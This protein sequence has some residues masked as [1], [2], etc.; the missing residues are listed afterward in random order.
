MCIDQV[1]GPAQDTS[2]D[3][4][5]C[6]TLLEYRGD[7]ACS[8]VG[9]DERVGNDALAGM[10]GGCAEVKPWPWL[11]PPRL[12]WSIG[13]DRPG[14]G[15]CEFHIGYDGNSDTGMAIDGGAAE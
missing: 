8:L 6:E 9:S 5:G 13:L 4:D 3:V 11:E 14:N 2:V 1:P 12:R 10:V 15:G 7:G